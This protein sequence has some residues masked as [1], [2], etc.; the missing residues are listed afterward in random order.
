MGGGLIRDDDC[1]I[2]AGMS[3]S[4]KRILVGTSKS[5]NKK[6]VLSLKFTNA[7]DGFF[8]S[9]NLNGNT[10]YAT[11]FIQAMKEDA[12]YFTQF[13]TH[14][15]NAWTKDSCDHLNTDSALRCYGTDDTCGFRIAQ[16]RGANGR[17]APT[18]CWRFSFRFHADEAVAANGFMIQVQEREGLSLLQQLETEMAAQAR[19]KVFRTTTNDASFHPDLLRRL[20]VAI[21]TWYGA[22]CPSPEVATDVS[23]EDLPMECDGDHNSPID[24]I[25]FHDGGHDRGEAWQSDRKGKPKDN[26]TIATIPKSTNESKANG[27]Q[28]CRAEPM[29]AH[30]L[31]AEADCTSPEAPTEHQSHA[32]PLKVNVPDDVLVEELPMD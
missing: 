29:P 31:E 17:P 21:E 6:V 19:L 28:L 22:G 25:F 2:A 9:R 14:N 16:N 5:E 18:C 10:D 30:N 26:K 8:T 12:L 15:P 4:D 23:L 27:D 7:A 24:F 11:H 3:L 32:M 13:D 20:Q 1:L